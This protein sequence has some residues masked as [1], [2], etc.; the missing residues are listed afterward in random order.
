MTVFVLWEN[1]ATGPVTRFGPH[2][3]LVAC[4]ANLL[5]TDRFELLRSERIKGRSCNGNSNVFRELARRPLWDAVP[6]LIAVLDTDKLHE[7]LGGEARKAGRRSGLRY[8]VVADGSE[9]SRAHRLT[10]GRAAHDLL[11]RSQP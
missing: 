10:R 5:A 4:V 1:H 3:F 6:H 2:T 11:P 8:L 9:V 7:L